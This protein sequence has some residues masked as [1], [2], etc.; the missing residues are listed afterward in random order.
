[1]EWAWL[2]PMYCLGAFILIGII[3]QRLQK[4]ASYLSV[5]AILAGFVTFLFVLFD[6]VSSGVGAYRFASEWFTVSGFNVELGIIVD[7]LSVVMLGLVT[8]VAL[9]VQVYSIG[10]M[11]GDS[12]TYWYF[13]VHSLFAASMLALVLVDNLLLLYLSWELV[14]LC[15][16]FLIGFWYERREASEAAKK[17]FITTR[18]GDVGLLI[19]ILMLVVATGTFDI[20]DILGHLADPAGRA[21]IGSTTITVSAILIFLGAMGKSAQFPLHV[22]LPDA[23]EGP[24]PVSALIHAATMVAAGVF[25]VAR[26]YPLYDVAEGARFMIAIVGVITVLAGAGMAMAA[27]DLKR[28]LAYSTMSHLGFMMLA[29]GAGGFTAAIFHLTT[30]GIAKAMLFLAAGSIMHS[31]HGETN[32]HKMGGLVQRMPITTGVFLIGGIAL[33]GIPPL[34][35]FW[36]KD[37]ILLAVYHGLNPVFFVMFL[38][39]A[40]LSAAY[41]ARAVRLVFFGDLLI[42]NQ[43]IKESPP[44]MWVP[45][46]IFGIVTLGVGLIALPLGSHYDGIGSFLFFSH[47]HE[48]QIDLMWA[49]L[50]TVMVVLTFTLTC[51]AYAAHAERVR[52][53]RVRYRWL[54][55]LF[56]HGLYMDRIYQAAIDRGVLATGRAI[57]MFDRVVINDRVVNWSGWVVLEAGAR[58]RGHVTGLFAD[59][60][61]IMVIGTV[62]IIGLAIFTV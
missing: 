46:V 53:F 60:G 16:Y 26:L 48:F 54:N 6:L 33:A 39:G 58:L 15:S 11:K 47:P 20:T 22:W 56:S 55:D 51:W 45:M 61:V 49:T 31:M 29:L 5:V 2:I 37:E 3:G 4:T 8:F 21:E 7:P 59:Y 13:G 1:M 18:I 30:H 42:S 57:G 38:M 12:R 34:S 17:A 62:V 14:G 24:T 35:A 52:S 19:G 9:G 41:M 10:Y 28:I 23:M 50:S 43:R 32:I 25:L 44:I 36:S 40:V 27:T